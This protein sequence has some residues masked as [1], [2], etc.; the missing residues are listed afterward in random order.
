MPLVGGTVML[1]STHSAP[2][3][4]PFFS[5]MFALLSR[6]SRSLSEVPFV[7]R[8]LRAKYASSG[9][10]PSGTVFGS[11]SSLLDEHAPTQMPAIASSTTIPRSITRV[12]ISRSREDAPHSSRGSSRAYPDHPSLR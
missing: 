7:M 12:Y 3:G 4:T 8:D 9:V 1:R 10:M 11:S 6:I 5:Q 2:L